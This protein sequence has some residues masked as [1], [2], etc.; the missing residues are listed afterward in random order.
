[1][2]FSCVLPKGRVILQQNKDAGKSTMELP[3][4]ASRVFKLAAISNFA[5]TLPVLVA[6]NHVIAALPYHPPN[7]PFLV[8][9]WS[10][11]AFLWGVMFWEISRDMKAKYALI[12]YT[13]LEKLVTSVSVSA[14]FAAGQVPLSFFV[15]ILFTDMIWIPIFA[16]IHL[17]ARKSFLEQ[18]A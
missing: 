11:M 16:T 6:Y 13:Y 8:W 10:G 14:G 12:K 5:V 7:Y 2:T 3:Q 17:M 15:L 1:M 9:I 4:I 18:K